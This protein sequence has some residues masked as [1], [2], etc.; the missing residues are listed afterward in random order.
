MIATDDGDSKEKEK[1]GDGDNVVKKK[2]KRRAKD[3]EAGVA[4]GIDFKN[5]HT[6]RT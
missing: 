1:D 2:S 6:V 4:R 3:T 5:V